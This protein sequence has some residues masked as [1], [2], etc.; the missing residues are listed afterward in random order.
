MTLASLE[1]SS[2]STSPAPGMVFAGKPRSPA[3]VTVVTTTE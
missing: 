2:S 3:T 1:L